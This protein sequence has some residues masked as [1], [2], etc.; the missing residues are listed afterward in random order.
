MT[1]QISSAPLMG[2]WVV[3][4][5]RV[6]YYSTRCVLSNIEAEAAECRRWSNDR[7]QNTD[8]WNIH[9]RNR[10]DKPKHSTCRCWLCAAGRQTPTRRA[11]GSNSLIRWILLSILFSDSLGLWAV[12]RNANAPRM[13]EF[14]L[15]FLQWNEWNMEPL[16]NFLLGDQVDLGQLQ[17]R[18]LHAVGR[19]CSEESCQGGFKFSI[20][21]YSI[22]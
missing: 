12:G 18:C 3:G 8:W 6:F 22:F 13:S 17:W 9:G 21:I 20:C 5:T 7:I 14:W 4:P 16:Y 10:D 2:F 15:D 1:S 11:A 19:L